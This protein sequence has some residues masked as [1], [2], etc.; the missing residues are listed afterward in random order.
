[1]AYPHVQEGE[2]GK[3]EKGKIHL[4]KAYLRLKP[5][6]E[7]LLHSPLKS[8]CPR[9]DEKGKDEE[10]EQDDEEED[11]STFEDLH[12]PIIEGNPLEGKG[13]PV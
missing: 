3:G 5:G 10:G 13:Y 11:F 8:P 7:F 2:M 12:G 1:M 9:S 4:G 6:G